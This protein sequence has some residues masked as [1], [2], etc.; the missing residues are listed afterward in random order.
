MQ[1]MPYSGWKCF[2]WIWNSFI[3]PIHKA[4][5]WNSCQ[6]V[7]KLATKYC[8]WRIPQSGWSVVVQLIIMNGTICK[9][10]KSFSAFT[11]LGHKEQCRRISICGIAN[12]PQRVTTIITT[13]PSSVFKCMSRNSLFTICATFYQ[14]SSQCFIQ[15]SYGSLQ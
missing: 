13:I 5:I 9:S 2:S 12:L 6:N 14:A 15:R 3:F 1:K 8:C 11:R 4:H 10:E 7:R